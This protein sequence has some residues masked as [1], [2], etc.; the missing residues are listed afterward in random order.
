MRTYIS[1]LRGINVSGQKMIKMADL[2]KLYAELGFMEIQSY[3]QSGNVIFQYEPSEP[4]E[5]EQK[6]TAGIRTA[7]SF[8]V[9]VMVLEI[10]ELQSVLANNPYIADPSKDDNFMHV[11][12]LSALPDTV[13]LTKLNEIHYPGEEFL[14]LDRAIYLYCPNGYGRTKFNNSFFEKKLKLAAT[15]RNW[16]TAKELLIIALKQTNSPS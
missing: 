15:T 9:P 10:E 3:I 13:A 1:I 5:L 16:K 8:E 12:F 2:K 6:I 4:H 11:T 7:Y 14:V